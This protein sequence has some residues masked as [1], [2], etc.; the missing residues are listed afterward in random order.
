MYVTI[1]LCSIDCTA[2]RETVG[3]L[4]GEECCCERKY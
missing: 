4:Q 1:I 2:L 3:N